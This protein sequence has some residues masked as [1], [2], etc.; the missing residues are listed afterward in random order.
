MATTK[1]TLQSCQQVLHGQTLHIYSEKVKICFIL[2]VLSVFQVI[3]IESGWLLEVA[4]HY[5][6][7]K[8]LEDSSS[9]KMPR[10]QG[11]AREELGWSWDLF[12][13][14]LLHWFCT[15]DQRCQRL[16]QCSYGN[17]QTFL[18]LE[19]PNFHISAKVVF[20]C[21]NEKIYFLLQVYTCFFYYN[22]YT[23]L[24]YGLWNYLKRYG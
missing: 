21:L 24:W 2:N 15:G 20:M 4:P 11:K 23:D 7:N 10:K 12:Q 1:T 19:T 17:D 3:E 16:H 14:I 18:I 9:K 13:P 6:K 22:F 5:Y 8:E